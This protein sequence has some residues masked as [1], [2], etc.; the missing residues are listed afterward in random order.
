MGVAEGLPWLTV[1]VEGYGPSSYGDRIADVYDDWYQSRLDPADAVELL[2][3]LA[4]DGPALE[5]GVGTGRVAVP[6]ARRGVR[7]V[8]IDASAAMVEKL[9]ARPGGQLV[10][11]VMGDFADV[12]VSGLFPLV[13][14]PFTTFFALGT[15]ER[16]L[17]CLHNVVVHLDQGGH[18]VLD[19][20]VPD[21]ARFGTTSQ[22]VTAD[23]VSL[24][25][26]VIDA[27]RHDA[28]AQTIEAQHVSISE[29]GIRLF[30]VHL[31]Y[32]WP[33]ELDLM[34]RLAG[35]KMVARYG[36]YDRRPF[37]GSCSHHVSVYRKDGA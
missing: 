7:V 18:F 24:D 26:V 36:A 28:V 13:Y 32:C 4:G 15:Q 33:S 9:R 30:P 3:E 17:E 22:A 11:V 27:A 37:D 19:A 21:V 35:L 2:V 31:R 34:A 12:D 8:G 16:Q 14:V 20:F 29:A 1:P 6:L 10:D 5:L 25:R 23:T